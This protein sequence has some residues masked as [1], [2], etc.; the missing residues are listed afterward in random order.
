MKEPWI[1]SEENMPPNFEG[2]IDTANYGQQLQILKYNFLEQQF[3]VLELI[4]NHQTQFEAWF[5][6]GQNIHRCSKGSNN[7]IKDVIFTID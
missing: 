1:W 6:F 7:Q 5:W 4:F 3:N 2:R